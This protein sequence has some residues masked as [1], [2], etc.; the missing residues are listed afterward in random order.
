MHQIDVWI[1]MQKASFNSFIK[2]N[3]SLTFKTSDGLDAFADFSEVDY[4][5]LVVI[6]DPSIGKDEKIF[7][8]S[9]PP[10]GCEHNE[11]FDGINP[12]IHAYLGAVAGDKTAIYVGVVCDECAETHMKDYIQE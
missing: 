3:E 11:H 9:K 5:W 10:C 1:T 7:D 12:K 2:R 8:D 4:R 6:Y